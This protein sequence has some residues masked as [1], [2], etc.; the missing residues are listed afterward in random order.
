MSVL[1]YPF[2][3]YDLLS[4]PFLSY[5]IPSYSIVILSY[6]ILAILSFLI[7]SFLI[8]SYLILFNCYPI[9]LI[10]INR[11]IKSLKTFI[12]PFWVSIDLIF[13]HRVLSSQSVFILRLNPNFNRVL[14]GTFI[15][16]QSLK[17][18]GKVIVIYT[19]H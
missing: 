15:S 2:I 14:S 12:Y 16:Q 19:V 3:P 18:F 8:L 5:P 1:S 13:K 6:S 4:Y 9:M 17:Y 10:H 11:I 7:L